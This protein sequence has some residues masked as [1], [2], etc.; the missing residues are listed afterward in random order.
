MTTN[1]TVKLDSS[2]KVH[3][4]ITW[5]FPHALSNKYCII[6][7]HIAIQFLTEIIIYRTGATGDLSDHTYMQHSPFCTVHLIFTFWELV[8]LCLKVF[9]CHYWYI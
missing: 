1:H 7:L 3:K 6:L 4:F 5:F 2:H 8:I 9:R